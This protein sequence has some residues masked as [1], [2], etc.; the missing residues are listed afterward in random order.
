MDYLCLYGHFANNLIIITLA[1][2]YNVNFV[3][4]VN[5]VC[6]CVLYLLATI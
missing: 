3:M 6:M 1:I 2:Y 5:I 4:F